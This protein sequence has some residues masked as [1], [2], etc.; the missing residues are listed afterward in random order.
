MRILGV[1]VNRSP[2]GATGCHT[3]FSGLV[4]NSSWKRVPAERS[5]IL[6]TDK[7]YSAAPRAS[8][9]TWLPKNSEPNSV[10]H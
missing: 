3:E 8:R 6:S 2:L 1:F 7:E 9:L 4:L 5:D 10:P